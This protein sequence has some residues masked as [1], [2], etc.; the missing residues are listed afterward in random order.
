MIVDWTETIYI[1]FLL[2]CIGEAVHS[3]SHKEEARG[4]ECAGFVK[5]IPN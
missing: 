4:A 2:H 1:T 5:A 3:G